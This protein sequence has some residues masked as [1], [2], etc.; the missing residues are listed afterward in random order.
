LLSAPLRNAWLGAT[1]P[2]MFIHTVYFYLKENTPPAAREQLKRDCVELLG[3][4]PDVRFCFAGTPAGTPRTV[5]DNSYGVGVTV[6]LTDAAAHDV[7]QTHPLHLDF[8][9]RNKEH[10]ARVQVY[11]H[12][13]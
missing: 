4:I 10:W 9:A 12:V 5:V 11:D 2:A 7:Y 6:V 8:I 13:E 1:I 3:Q